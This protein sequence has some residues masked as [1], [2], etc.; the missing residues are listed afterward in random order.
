MNKIYSK[1]WNKELGQLIVASEFASSDSAGVVQ[2][3][4]AATLLRRSLLAAVGASLLALA[5]SGSAFAQDMDLGP[6]GSLIVGDT[7]IDTDGVAVGAATLWSDGLSV[8]GGPSVTILGIDAGN[9]VITNVADGTVAHHAVN[10]G[11]LDVVTDAAGAAQGA[12]DAAQLAADQN[13]S[14]ITTNT[15]NI[16]TNADDIVGLEADIATNRDEIADVRNTASAGWN[17]S[18][19]GEA[20]ANVGAGGSVDFS[21][22]GN[23]EVSR[24][25]TDLTIGLGDEIAVD[26]V[27]VG[28]M[29]LDSAGMN[30]GGKVITNL[31][32][33]EISEMS[34]DA[35]TGQQV[36]DLFF[37]GGTAFGVRYFRVKSTAADSQA[38][39]EESLAIGPHSIAQ[40]DSSFAAGDGA[41]IT[42]TA[43]GAIALGQGATAGTEAGAV[44]D[45]V[46]SIAMGRD[47]Q[48]AGNSTVALGDGASI[49]SEYI[50][51][52][53]ALGA[54]ARV[55][56]N[57]G[58]GGTAVG[59]NA[60]A[61][62]SNATALGTN[63]QASGTGGVAVGQANAA[64]DNAIAAGTGA[65]VG[66]AN[67]IALGTDAGVGTGSIP[68]GDRTDHIAI[69]TAAGQDVTGNQSTAIGYGAGQ[70]VVGDGNVALGVEAGRGLTGNNNIS[71]GVNANDGAGTRAQAIAIGDATEAGSDSVALGSGARAQGSETLALGKDSVAGANGIALGAHSEAEGSNI[72]LGRNSAARESDLA[73]AGYLTGEPVPGSA[74]SV[75]NSN[76][77]EAFQRRITNVSD[78]SQHYDAVNV[79][80]LQGA[81]RS[82]ATLV[83]GGVTLN[84]DGTYSPIVVDVAGGGTAS[85]A[86][87]VEA[88]GAVTSG[89]VDILPVDAVRYNAEGGISNVAAGSLGT[90]AVN[91]EQ[92]NVAIAE[93]GVKYFSANST[94]ST[95]PE[96]DT[97]TGNRGND[98]ATADNAMAI[99]PLAVASGT[100]SLAVGHAAR[101]NAGA[102]NGVAIG[103]DVSARAENSTVLGNQSHSYDA[104]GVAIGQEAVSRGQNSIVM[105]T[106]AEADPKSGD[107]VN[108][109]IVIGTVAE[110]TADDGIAIGRSALASEERAVA[111]GFDAHAM[112][113]DSQAFG[114][115]A[116][117]EGVSSQAS[118]TD[119]HANGTNAIATG[120]D[121]R[122]H[123]VDGIAM[124]TGAVAGFVVD[125]PGD[126]ARNHG[127]I[128]IGDSSM[129]DN[130]NALA[131]G[132]GAQA[133]AGSA[134]AIGDAAIATEEAED[135]L[136]VGSGAL[137]TAQNASA[138]GQSAAAT[139]VDALAVG[140]GAS[141]S[142]LD[143]S[144][145]GQGA[146]ASHA[147]S[148]AL[149][150]DSMTAVA[151]PESSRTVGGIVYGPY[152]GNS[153]DSVVSVGSVGDERQVT[154][155]AAG[156]V[157]ATSTDAINGSQLFATN[158][159]L[160]NVANSLADGSSS[161][162]GGN[163]EVGEDGTITMSDVGGTGESNVHD[164]IEYAAQ[165]WDVSAQSGD[166]E[167]V[168]PGGSVDFSNTDQNIEIDRNGTNLVF[169]L[170]DNL[171]VGN[172]ISFEGGDTQITG[173][174]I[175]TNDLTVG[176]E[177]QLGANFVVNGDGEAVYNGF[178]I[179]TQ[180]DG[181]S[182]AGN[183]GD[184]IDKTLGDGT[185]L[186]IQG[187][188]ADAADATGL[189]LRVDSAGGQLNLVMAQDLTDLN[190]ITINGG[191]VISDDG[192]D[193]VDHQISNLA[194]GIEDHHAVN[195]GQLNELRDAVSGGWTVTDEGGNAADIG[196]D[197]QVE[198]RGDDNIAVAQT[199]EDDAGVV[200]IA[201]ND[202]IT[203]GD[204]DEAVTIDGE[205][206]LV[207][208]GDTVIDGDGVAVEDEDGNVTTV[209][210]G[211]V[212]VTDSAGSSRIE[213]GP[214]TIS[215]ADADGETD[216]SGSQ[217]SVGGDY[218]VVISGESGT[219]EGLT[220]QDLDG[221]D[222]AQAGRAATEE[223]LGL[224]NETA[225]MGWNVGVN[226]DGTAANVAPGDTVDFGNDD[227]NIVI[228]RDGTD[229]A[230]NLD[231][232]IAVDSLALNGTAGADGLTI[233]GAQGAPG[234][235]G[236]DGITRIVYTDDEGNDREVATM[237]DGLV[238]AGNT[239]DD[240]A[241]S[242]G[243]TLTLSGEL[244]DDDDATG[245]NLRVDSDGDQLNLVMAQDLTDL[246][247]ITINNGGP[248]ISGDGINMAGNRITNLDRGVDGTDAVN[249]D[250]LD[251]VSDAA[252]AGWNVSVD[253]EGALADGSNN[254]APGGTVEFGNTDGNI[255]VSRD[256]TDLVFDLADEITVD[257]VTA[258]EVIAGDTTID[259]TGVAVGTDVHLGSTG[260]VINGGPSVT[261]AGIDAG[262]L[263][264][265]NVAPGEIS[266]TSTDAINGSQLH[267]MG[268]SIVNVIGGNAEL[269]PDGTIVTSDIGGTGHDNIDDAIRSANDAANAGWTATDADGNTAN[270]GPGGTVNFTGDGN[271]NVAQTGDDDSGEVEIT[272]NRDL[273]VDSITAGNTVIDSD[274][275]QVGDDVH[276]G[277]T[278]LVIEGGPSVTTDGIDAGG[279]VVSNVAAGVED[280]DAANVG[281]IRAV[282]AE[283]NGLG[284]RMD[285][286]EGD[287]SG[288]QAGAAGPFQVSQEAPV[289]APTPTGANAAA[290]GSGA[291]ASGDNSTALG[292]QAVASGDNSTAVGQ[293]AQATHDNSVA[294]GRGSATTVGAQ[295]GY[296]AAY[297]GSSDSAGEVNVG[298]RTV[299][300]VAPG[301]AGT[302]AVN[303]NQ[304]QGGV[305]HAVVTANAYTDQRIG[306]VQS[307]VW[308]LHGRVDELERDINA[309]VATAMA[310]RQAPYVAGATTYYAGFGAYK[311]QGAL[312]VSL[313]RT[314]DNG[315]WSLEGGFSA[316]RDGAGGYIGVSGVLGSK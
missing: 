203:L 29:T 279:S 25:G 305:N 241:K 286:V 42:A 278:G 98:G 39:G 148:V 315:R 192:I 201:L 106:G 204:G 221:A 252:N 129:A 301:V 85:F 61:S 215:V 122:G 213:M 186:V 168:A 81:Q 6:D 49:A 118:G 60:H 268:D 95:D 243:E 102:H 223:Q 109:A 38:L 309:G 239:G 245:A 44:D 17:I 211:G 150:A 297:V 276:L 224:V 96:D 1:V 200:E 188:L 94:I 244:A 88:I 117:A 177:T 183:T 291:D 58:T 56:T 296:D 89:E 193:M 20:T 313:R 166:T 145:F 234:L 275:V 137:V 316:N 205:G 12:A 182:F 63:A 264:I 259:T 170:N 206:G 127:S 226:A 269:N 45:G 70:G 220:N 175:T 222:F 79:G 273:D 146:Q 128:A 75:G 142:A 11:Q 262:N 257:R 184:G 227:G 293:G 14:A 308:Q 214:G 228:S 265:T 41:T 77:G 256:G 171:E 108:D 34:T 125:V 143:A 236:T 87:I 157:T 164:A 185:P 250:Q 22:D 178:E 130:L 54:G 197:G 270:I 251:E 66:T 10:R 74:V 283:V 298:N 302:D 272:L 152:A 261:L 132:V 277:D 138:F 33:G 210:A 295:S 217:V 86:T 271:V 65:Y 174:G 288:L 218:Q 111:Q 165:G 134:T 43:E 254:V 131:L 119:A 287:V 114:T 69:G 46:G 169:D 112:A 67:S 124:G 246:N 141:A 162:L 306:Q 35:V 23:I 280:T 216:I 15:T 26:R 91:V 8:T 135:G 281:Q 300:G 232:D 18:A 180:A 82:V 99:G 59:A 290:G 24:S 64:A 31:A 235:A 21:G 255:E 93:N 202:S 242:L 303:V 173:D 179:A 312:G 140:S 28:G 133:G 163:V 233:R 36:H 294:L 104:G 240:I 5:G 230:F 172:S 248:I 155:V 32:N 144:A 139:A 27:S 72:A 219:I 229:L 307:D 73:G 208:V 237:N 19:E 153:P 154:N 51:D 267:G 97:S 187:E 107:T 48:A 284:D 126:E 247:S 149:G 7:F 156:R 292:N 4:G 116:R 110:A 260:L 52:A 310:M 13:A 101:V 212:T 249:L 207:S 68:G 100:S 2:G 190:S 209:A 80:Q 158:T 47:S 78:G 113:D 181:L 161:V 30:A 194:D 151:N 282:S 253:D 103:H 198:F 304:L 90:D 263:V 40:G 176:G 196:A 16:A 9:E 123:A 314:S 274:G 167:N 285:V 191:P 92:L 231:N 71:I 189:N 238:F 53:T 62:A 120:T 299:S 159:V 57:F 55:T 37:E 105:G 160:G 76:P 199:G 84:A 195:L 121:S 225:N 311:D 3:A 289:V 266:A 83:G 136:A 50:A 147:G 115:R 258:G